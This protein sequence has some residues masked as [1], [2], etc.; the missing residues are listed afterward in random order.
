M[1]SKEQSYQH[2]A[3][4][5]IEDK[6]K[7]EADKKYNMNLL[8]IFTGYKENKL[9]AFYIY[10]SFTTTYVYNTDEYEL[11]VQMCQNMNPFE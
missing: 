11:Y 10:L 2:L 5:V 6:M 3:E 8:S 9:L 4:L 7:V 1:S